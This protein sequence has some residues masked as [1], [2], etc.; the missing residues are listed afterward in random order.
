[1][2]SRTIKLGVSREERKIRRKVL[3]RNSKLETE[4]PIS[5]QRKLLTCGERRA[6]EEIKTVKTGERTTM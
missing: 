1:M 3:K 6:K 4:E 2:N 5:V